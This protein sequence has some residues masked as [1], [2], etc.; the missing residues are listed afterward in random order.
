M[1]GLYSVGEVWYLRHDLQITT[2]PVY[3]LGVVCWSIRRRALLYVYRQE[4]TMTSINISL[5]RPIDADIYGFHWRMG[6][7]CPIYTAWEHGYGWNV[8]IKFKL[9][10]GPVH[11]ISHNQKVSSYVSLSPWSKSHAYAVCLRVKVWTA[12]L[13]L[14]DKQAETVTDKHSN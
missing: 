8:L 9:T 13:K 5:F 3:S 2:M 10:V 11:T 6:S 1:V 7:I 14:K 12:I 4:S